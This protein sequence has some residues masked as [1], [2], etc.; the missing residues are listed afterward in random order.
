MG[1]GAPQVFAN[2]GPAMP[3]VSRT[4]SPIENQIGETD[5]QLRKF[6]TQDKT[7]FGSPTNHPGVG[8]KILHALSVAG[9][10]AGDIFAPNEMSL[11]PRT[12]R[13]R[14]G[15]ENKLTGRLKELSQE[16]SEEDERGAVT[17]KTDAETTEIPADSAS[18]RGV[19]D[20]TAGNLESETNLRNNPRPT[21]QI[22]DTPQGLMRI[23]VQQGIAQP[24]TANG[25]AVGSP[26]KTLPPQTI[27]VG[28]VPHDVLFD[29]KGQKV[30]DLGVHYEKPNAAPG[31]TMVIPD[32]QGGGKVE[33]LTPGSTVA[34][35]AMSATQFGSTNT[36]TSQMR[37]AAVQ[38]SLVHE[39]MPQLIQQIDSMSNDLGPV[40]GQWNEYMQ[41]KVGMD[42]P[43]FADLRANLLMMSSAVALM[44]AR[45][46]LPENLREEFDHAINAPKQTAANLKAVLG[47]IDQWTVANMNMMGGERTQHGAGAAEAPSQL[48]PGD[49]V[50]G[51]KYLG[52]DKASQSNWQKVEK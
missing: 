5:Q 23:D 39:Q 20:A 17:R 33:R 32:G 16:G 24:V 35:G 30:A 45:G 7:P 36:P 41:G 12:E 19:E 9:N 31:V 44:H 46:R 15:Q 21:Y 51:Y 34:P 47:R 38:A 8:G 13:Y 42:N 28:G 37:N 43:K 49:V 50:D 29:N 4:P 52:G 3:D 10:I 25:E 26:I 18:R 6:Q 14:E 40:A 1:S 2:G 22:H 48:N 27:M 11:I